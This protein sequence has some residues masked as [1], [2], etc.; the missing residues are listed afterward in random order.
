MAGCLVDPGE[1]AFHKTTAKDSGPGKRHGVQK[2]GRIARSSHFSVSLH[3]CRI[4]PVLYCQFATSL[5]TT[6][7]PRLSYT[8]LSWKVNQH[9]TLIA[10]RRP[11]QYMESWSSF[12]LRDARPVMD[13]STGVTL[14]PPVRC[15][16]FPRPIRHLRALSGA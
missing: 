8:H 9:C 1:L 11:R 2:P 13:L 10:L 5:V 7:T 3:A 15:L 16:E 14:L 12:G 4:L 6:S